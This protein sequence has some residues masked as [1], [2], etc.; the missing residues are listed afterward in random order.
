VP[1][2]KHVPTGCT[3]VIVL[4]AA[5][6]R[7]RTLVYGPQKCIT[8]RPTLECSNR[9]C[10]IMIRIL[11]KTNLTPKKRDSTMSRLQKYLPHHTLEAMGLF[12]DEIMTGGD[13]V[14][15][16]WSLKHKKK[17]NRQQVITTYRFSYRNHNLVVLYS[18]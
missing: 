16:I 13:I 15:T 7:W 8:T 17:R 3:D 14:P 5:G 11:P 9:A 2:A 10:H 12:W 1:V 18:A 6:I 4:N